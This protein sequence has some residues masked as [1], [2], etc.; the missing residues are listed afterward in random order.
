MHAKTTMHPNY[1][2]LVNAIERN[3][4]L[5]ILK[6]GLPFQL[7]ENQFLKEI[8]PTLPCR[9]TLAKR[10]NKI[11]LQLLQFI[12]SELNETEEITLILDEWSNSKNSKFAVQDQLQLMKN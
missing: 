2:Q 6:Q 4:Q 1:V 8:C 11:A 10:A 7:I 5:F 12:Q 9:E 3:L